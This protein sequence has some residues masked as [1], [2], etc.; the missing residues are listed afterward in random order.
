MDVAGADKV[1]RR[2]DRG[3]GYDYRRDCSSGFDEAV[4]AV[5]ESLSR[6]GFTVRT[7][8]DIQAT[9]AAKGFRIRP[10][11]IYEVVG[12]RDPGSPG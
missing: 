6:H 10:I 2:D 4:V 12:P 5:E 11:R 7:V 8:H 1:D 3:A 9:L